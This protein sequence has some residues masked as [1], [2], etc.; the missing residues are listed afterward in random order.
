MESPET[1]EHDDDAGESFV[2]DLTQDQV[3][4]VRP[5]EIS[6]AG[7]AGVPISKYEARSLGATVKRDADAAEPVVGTDRPVRIEID[8]AE[9]SEAPAPAKEWTSES[10]LEGN[11]YWRRDSRR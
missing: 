4:A 3:A 2:I 6:A 8:I 1:V 11:R 10:S 5:A 7:E 9:P